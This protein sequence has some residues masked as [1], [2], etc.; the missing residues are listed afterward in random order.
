MRSPRTVAPPPDG[1]GVTAPCPTCRAAPRRSAR[2]VKRRGVKRRDREARLPVVAQTSG[3]G[4]CT[5][6]GAGRPG[7]AGAEGSRTAA[8]L[9]GD[10]ARAVGSSLRRR[11]GVLLLAEATGA[12]PEATGVTP[13][14]LFPRTPRVNSA[15]ESPS[16]SHRNGV[17]P[18]SAARTGG[19]VGFDLW[20][21]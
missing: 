18:L 12:T 11:P 20:G 3:R 6:G 17:V 21:S 5:Q 9:G 1:G 7:G 2:G 16:T 15:G 19:V 10:T 13:E 4:A 8:C 14:G